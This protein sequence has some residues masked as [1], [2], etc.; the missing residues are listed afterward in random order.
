MLYYKITIHFRECS[1]GIQSSIEERVST[2]GELFC[3]AYT[4]PC[5]NNPGSQ[6][7]FAQ[8]RLQF[9]TMLYYKVLENIMETEKKRLQSR[10]GN[11]V[12]DLSVRTLSLLS[13]TLVYDMSTW[14]Q[15]SG[16]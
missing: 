5:N 12:V 7:S 9:A 6:V 4:M 11:K 10:S 13:N 16:G 2:M 15:W 3:E 1:E 8:N 14:Q